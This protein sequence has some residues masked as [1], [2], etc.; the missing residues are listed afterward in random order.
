MAENETKTPPASAAPPP[1]AQAAAPAAEDA[2]QQAKA[3]KTLGR[4]KDLN[5]WSQTKELF[6]DL[7]SHDRPTRR[8][9][10][11]FTASIAGVIVVLVAGSIYFTD[12]RK[13]LA[14]N[15]SATG[16]Q[17]KNLNE[18]FQRKSDEAKRKNSIQS[19]GTF[20]VELKSAEPKQDAER[21]QGVM[22]L[23]DL[24]IVVQ[25][26]EKTTC[27]FIEE[28]MPLVRNEVTGVFVALDRDELLSREGK[29]RLRKKLIDKL[30]AWLPKGK[31]IDLFFD[32]LIVS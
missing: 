30:N 4:L 25:C 23:A 9:A 10:S 32:K 20:T 14:A 8:M 7:F 21:A 22:N 18:F 19:L 24:E 13:N 27:E 28:R 31:V 16:E 2:P 17:G 1:A 5:L 26:D 11:Y 3:G 29:H 6:Q 12:L 15:L